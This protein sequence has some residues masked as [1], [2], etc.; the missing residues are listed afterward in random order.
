MHHFAAARFQP[1]RFVSRRKRA[2]D[3][4]AERIPVQPLRRPD[5]DH[6]S[7]HEPQRFGAGD[8]S[9]PSPGR[10][11]PSDVEANLPAGPACAM[12]LRRTG[13][14]LPDPGD[15][16]RS[17]RVKTWD[18]AMKRLDGTKPTDEDIDLS[19]IKAR[20]RRVF[21][22][23]PRDY[24]ERMTR[25]ANPGISDEL[26]KKVLD[27]EVGHGEGSSCHGGRC[28]L[29]SFRYGRTCSS[30]SQRDHSSG[31]E[32]PRVPQESTDVSVHR[33]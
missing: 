33:P 19:A 14:T 3:D 30:R 6:Q 17:L 16:D 4:G 18:L 2:R 11:A 7:I 8:E 5:S 20:T 22:C 28:I 23:S 24:L 26:V 12:D 21:L 15:F 1:A 29:A 9:D 32:T 31:D 25:Q 27:D 13:D 10:V